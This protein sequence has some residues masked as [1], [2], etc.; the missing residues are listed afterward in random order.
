MTENNSSK[1]KKEDL[2]RQAVADFLNS[3]TGQWILRIVIVLA[4]FF[5]VKAVFF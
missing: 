4:V 5:L 1:P 2:E 3:T